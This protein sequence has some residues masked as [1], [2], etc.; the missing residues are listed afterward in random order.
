M[1]SSPWKVPQST[2][3]PC[4]HLLRWLQATTAWWQS[5]SWNFCSSNKGRTNGQKKG[6]DYG[7][8]SNHAATPVPKSVP[9]KGQVD[10][11]KRRKL[12]LP[13]VWVLKKNKKNN[14]TVRQSQSCAHS[15]FETLCRDGCS[16]IP[17]QRKRCCFPQSLNWRRVGRREA[18]A[19]L[20]DA[21]GQNNFSMCKKQN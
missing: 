21:G 6:W 2:N 7:S 15:H 8:H 3:D 1:R 13:A 18:L 10:L 11:R 16:Q 9:V 5:S 4:S 12:D 17:H 19:L 14:R 20:L